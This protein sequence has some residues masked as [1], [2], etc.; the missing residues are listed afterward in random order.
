MKKQALI[1]A[2]ILA[3]LNMNAQQI[4]FD[5]SGRS[6]TEV[7]AKEYT[8]WQV[9]QAPSD[10]KTIG[11]LTIKVE[12]SSNADVLRAQ[13]SK[14]DIKKSET[15]KLTGD[16]VVAFI[17]EDGNTPVQTNKSLG[18]KFTISGLSEGRHTI[19]AYHNGVNNLKNLAPIDIYVDDVKVASN[20]PQTENAQTLAEASLSYINIYATAGKDVVVE[21]RTNTS[22]GSY[23]ASMPYVNALIFDKVN[24]ESQAQTPS[25]MN[26]D[27]HV[28]A[29]NGNLTL[30]FKPATGA[31]KHHI[32]LGTDPE[33]L[34]EVSS[35]TLTSYTLSDLSNLNTYYWRV[36]EEDEEGNITTGE[37]W[38]F[39]TRHLAFPGAEG[40]GKYAIGGRGGSVYHVTTLEDNGDDINP[41]EGS[42]RYAIKKAKG[43][44][45]IVFD[46]SGIISL[47]SRLTCSDPYVTIAGQTAPGN[48]IM[49]KTSPFGM[50]TDGITRFVRMRL[51]HKALV[52]GVIPSE[53]NGKSYGNKANT[54]DEYIISG[55]DG[56]GMAG[57]TN[58]IMDH[59]SI[60]WTI[61]EAFSSRNSQSVTLQRT[62]ISEAL[63]QAGHPNYDEGTRHGYAATIG[64]GE[65][66]NELTV[67]SYHHNLLAHNEGRNWSLSG[68]LDGVG[69]Y[70]GHH[71][72]F[73]NVVY[74]WGNRSTDGG[75][76]EANFVGNYFKMGPAT[77]QSKTLVLELEGK[78]SGTQSVYVNGNLRQQPNNGSLNE[79]KKGE[80]YDYKL[81]GNQ[82]LNWEP[83]VSS[84]FFESLA[85]VE[86]AKSAYKNVLSDVGANQPFF[87]VHDQRM[88]KETI[89]GTYTVTG[90][91]SG[92]KGLPDSEEDAG[93]EGFNGLN[94]IEESRPADFDT[95]GDGMPDWWEN[96]T[97]MTDANGD[98]NNDGYTNLEDYLNWMAEPHFNNLNTIEL[99]PYFAGYNNNPSF[100]VIESKGVDAKINGTTLELAP[101]A[102][103]SNLA[104][105]VVEATDEDGWG[106]YK[107]TFHFAISEST[108]INII[109]NTNTLAQLSEETFNLAGQRV[110]KDYKG[111]VIKQGKKY[112][113]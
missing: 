63:N 21:Y 62:L 111:I 36:D 58:A 28:N 99:K 6:T 48:G 26:G 76:H 22:N 84:P 45:T 106:S 25:P 14:N 60:S 35:N 1:V 33:S 68:G 24:T 105:V 110:N 79:D 38:N 82:V 23:G 107:R 113:K 74:N 52:D 18:I 7:T 85:T 94:M 71:D 8:S 47:K 89:N 100:S 97:G 44:R 12:A 109:R 83:F 103:G 87:D 15:L 19:Q 29:D 16:A 27:F 17:N 5:M 31:V 11:G 66:S 91:R 10:T 50:A 55:I 40:Y 75:T 98:D 77:T 53:N 67:G 4:D 72:L 42:F 101:A 54:S 57:N 95:D 78:G 9:N 93:C 86:D 88:V 73:N 64:G 30:S 81:K 20:V 69:A 46:V 92:K 61:D 2:A 80:T 59:C 56:M 65:M 96:A 13:W 104:T 49:L 37:V 102:N 90:S 41:I 39:R 112:T 70:D 34:S 51:G 43:P 3:T 32:Y 108:G